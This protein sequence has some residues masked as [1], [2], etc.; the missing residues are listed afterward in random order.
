MAKIAKY[1]YIYMKALL[2]QHLFQAIS[3]A[4]PIIIII[5]ISLF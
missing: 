4:R 5:I 1:V 2:R 3:V